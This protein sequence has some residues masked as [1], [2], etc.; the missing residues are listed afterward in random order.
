M[1]RT[2]QVLFLLK[3]TGTPQLC[4]FCMI[5]KFDSPFDGLLVTKFDLV[6][7]VLLLN[8]VINSTPN[9]FA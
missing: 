1:I 5:G 9:A 2:L 6:V 4:S 3:V 8:V 7:N